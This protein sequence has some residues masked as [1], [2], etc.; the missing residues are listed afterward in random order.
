MYL[1]FEI[2]M[3]CDSV[4]YFLLASARMRM[5]S[6]HNEVIYLLENKFIYFCEIKKI[7]L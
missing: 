6:L 1:Q 3:I 7:A 5:R 2:R 4:F